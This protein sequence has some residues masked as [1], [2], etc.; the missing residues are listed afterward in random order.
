[1]LSGCA[2]KNIVDDILG[3]VPDPPPPPPRPNGRLNPEPPPSTGRGG[4]LVNPAE[5]EAQALNQAELEGTC[6]A[7]NFYA[8][9]GR[10]P[11][12]SEWQSIALRTALGKV[13]P[14]QYQ[15]RQFANS[16]AADVEQ[17]GVTPELAGQRTLELGC[18]R[19]LGS[20]S[21]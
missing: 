15:L 20:A 9:N 10:L 3:R 14:R 21:K 19:V 7:L 6:A 8:Q 11:N 1:M 4:P 5:R 2:G 18:T 13:T 17:N 16:L 12:P